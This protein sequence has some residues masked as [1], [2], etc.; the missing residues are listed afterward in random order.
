MQD[1]AS[2]RARCPDCTCGYSEQRGGYSLCNSTAA[3]SQVSLA[4][5]HPCGQPPLQ[6]PR[7]LPIAQ[8]GKP[9]T[10]GVPRRGCGGAPVPVQRRRIHRL[11][12]SRRARAAQRAEGVAEPQRDDALLRAV[13]PALHRAQRHWQAADQRAAAAMECGRCPDS[14]GRHLH[15][16]PLADRAAH[17]AHRHAGR[18]GARLAHAPKTNPKPK[19]VTPSLSHP[20]R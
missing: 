3:W 5:S 20:S 1:L 6:G 19:P 7:R 18:H 11:W 12:P 16:L 15:P 8:D 2:A 4:R 9:L 14:R 10:P 13:V 17:T